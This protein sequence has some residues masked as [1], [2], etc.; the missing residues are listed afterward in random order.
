M[1]AVSRF[2]TPLTRRAAI[3]VLPFAL[4]L[5]LAHIL[6]GGEGPGDGFTAGV[7]SGLAV[8]LWYI[9]FGYYETRQR[10]PWLHP[11][12]LVAVG[13]LV[14]LVNALLPMVF[15]REFLALTKLTGVELPA[16]LHAASTVIFEIAIFLTVFGGV[17]VIMEAIAHPKE[18]ERL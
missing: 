13:L 17:S 18:V 4:I 6:Y 12:R 16:H 7:V 11:G 3:I 15:G 2:S 1:R 5:S 9:V 10:L 14:A 8:A